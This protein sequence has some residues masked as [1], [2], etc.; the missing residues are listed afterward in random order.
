MRVPAFFISAFLAAQSVVD[1][2][3]IAQ[4]LNSE[5]RLISV[6]GLPANFVTG[7][8]GIK[9]LAYSNDGSIEWRLEAGR[10]TVSAEGKTAAFPTQSLHAE[11]RG[12][13]AFLP[14]SREIVR[15]N[16]DTLEPHSAAQSTIS[17]RGIEW[18]NGRLRVRQ[19]DGS[20]EEVGCPI[21]P[22]EITAAAADWASVLIA[23][24]PYL[25]DIRPGRVRLYFIPGGKT[26]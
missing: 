19:G 14:D 2:P 26:E 23:G 1:I 25:L 3:P 24:H 16:G 12:R 13:T 5:S 7:T 18:S 21:E 11:F 20:S 22:Q 10:L 15:F 4:L 8:P 17:G 9:L 6:Y